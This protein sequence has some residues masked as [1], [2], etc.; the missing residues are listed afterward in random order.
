MM[1]SFLKQYTANLDFYIPDRYSEG[2][3]VSTDG[4][5]WA[6]DHNINLIISLD[7]GIKAHQTIELA[8]ANNIDFIVCDHHAP[9]AVL[10]AAVAVLDP[11]RNDCSYPYKELSGCGVG[12]NL[13]HGLTIF[14][15]WDEAQLWPL[16]DL[17]AVSIAADIVP[18]TG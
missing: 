10:P 6:I 7:C 17:V 15:Q 8:A 11:K 14:K 5:N 9:D 13:L 3:G 16:L 4:I 18:I 12:F 1:I 2:Y